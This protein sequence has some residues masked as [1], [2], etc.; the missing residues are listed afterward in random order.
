MQEYKDRI[1]EISKEIENEIIELSDSIYAN[2]ESGNQ[3]FIA[4]N[5]HVAI[6]EKHGFEVEKPYL[7]LNT[8]FRAEYRSKKP[9]PRIC[10]MAEYDALP[11]IG[12]GCGHNLLGATST[13]AGI[14]LSKF[15][16]ELGGRVIVLGTPAEE[17]DGAKVHYVKKG[18]FD[19]I[20]LA[21]ISHPTG[22]S[23]YYKSGSALAIDTLMFE[24]KGRA[25]HAAA[26]AEKGVN[27]LDAVILTFNNI[28]ALRQQTRPDAR[29]H[30]IISEGGVAPNI[31]PD[32]CVCK[33]YVRAGTKAYLHRLMKQVENCAKGAALATGCELKIGPFEIAYENL[34]TNEA[35]S[36]V[37]ERS[38]RELGETKIKEP[39]EDYGSLDSGNV[40]Q[41]CPTIHPYF[42]VSTVNIPSHTAEFAECTRTPYAHEKMM[43]TACAMALSGVHIIREP[44]TFAAIRNEF[45]RSRK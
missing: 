24:F 10:Y 45:N 7:G 34:V 3:E 11:E 12:H 25:A 38:L 2:P 28:N 33:F 37:F 43:Q 17:T 9:G 1:L 5:L 42:P 40:S 31:I 36:D 22:G 35:L 18:A 29:I 39:G 4:S 19:D 16:G 41:V 21:M 13:A 6:L 23:Y 15:I 32:H 14:I 30:G 44:G 8:G 26:E 20:D 27:A